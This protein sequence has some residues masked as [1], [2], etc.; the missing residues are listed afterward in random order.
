M[1][2]KASTLDEL[3]QYNTQ[4]G[5][6]ALNAQDKKDLIA[7]LKTLSDPTFLANEKYK[8]PFYTSKI[9]VLS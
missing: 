7:F 1:S 9:L 5:G 4:P 3:L 8:S 6:L 2:K